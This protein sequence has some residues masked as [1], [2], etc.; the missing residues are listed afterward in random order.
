VPS[1]DV[2]YSNPG[3][4]PLGHC[5][6]KAKK[7]S[8]EAAADNGAGCGGSSRLEHSPS[9]TM[10]SQDGAEQENWGSVVWLGLTLPG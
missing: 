6:C 2:A 8:F 4:S 9:Q 1:C 7:S 3:L 10:L 5:S